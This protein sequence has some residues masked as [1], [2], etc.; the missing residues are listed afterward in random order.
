MN[1]NRTKTRNINK[2][3]AGAIAN[4]D[5]IEVRDKSWCA[6]SIDPSNDNY[7]TERIK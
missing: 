2:A 3:G 1:I 6:P 7:C 5:N 4:D